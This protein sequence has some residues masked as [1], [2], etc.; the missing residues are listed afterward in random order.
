MANTPTTRANEK[1]PSSE[2]PP[3]RK[4]LVVVNTG[5][6]KGKS[7]AAF[8]IMF[9]AWGRGM[10]VCAVQF[11]KN[12]KSMY[13]EQMAAEKL[14]IEMIPSGRGFTWTSKD[15]AEDASRARNGWR[16]AKEIMAAGEHDVVVLD[17][18]TYPMRYGWIEI[19][20]VVE[21][22][23]A[24]PPMV[25]VVL[26]GR[27]APAEIIEAADLVTEMQQVKHP[28]HDQNIRAQRGIEF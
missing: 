13:G 4:G 5:M 22:L 1:T 20:E 28:Y 19:D 18:I 8:G 15:L 10:K 9:R 11:I 21:T 26:T 7:T 6:G 12:D 16:I 3:R 25:H 23:K 24:R 14:G 17:E 27:H 2:R